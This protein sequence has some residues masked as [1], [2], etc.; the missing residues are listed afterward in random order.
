MELSQGQFLWCAAVLCFVV[1]FVPECEEPWVPIISSAV[2]VHMELVA[3]VPHD[4]KDTFRQ[5][6]ME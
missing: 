3:Q 1:V 4:S 6:D 2:G 5:V